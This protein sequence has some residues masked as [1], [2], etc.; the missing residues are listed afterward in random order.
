MER[1]ITITTLI[2]AFGLGFVLTNAYASGGMSK[3]R[4]KSFETSMLIG[5]QVKDAKG[6]YVGTIQDFVFDSNGHIDF[7]ILSHYFSDFNWEYV[8]YYPVPLPRET[9]AIPFSSITINHHNEKNAILK[10]SRSKLD[11]APRRSK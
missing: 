11:S 7:V 6:T 2:L 1:I 10:F 5:T 4:F 9:V 8:P 3:D